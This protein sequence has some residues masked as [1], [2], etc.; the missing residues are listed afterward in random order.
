MPSNKTPSSADLLDRLLLPRTARDVRLTE[1][2]KPPEDWSPT[3]WFMAIPPFF[4]EALDIQ[5]TQR[6]KDKMSMLVWTQGTTFHFKAGDMLY[7]TKAA[8]S[9]WEEALPHIG[10]CIQVTEGIAAGS[11][12]P[13]GSRGSGSIDFAAFKP[14][15]K[16]DALEK[17]CEHSMTQDDFVRFLICG[18]DAT[19]K[20]KLV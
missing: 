6:I 13:D 19:L 7:D 1:L 15:H 4:N 18:P 12:L 3:E 11:S 9:P 14:N 5:Q 10:L 2:L 20:S 16:R 17:V 8:Y